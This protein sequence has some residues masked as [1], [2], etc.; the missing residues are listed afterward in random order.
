MITYVS[1]FELEFEA[2]ARIILSENKMKRQTTN[3]ILYANSILL[4]FPYFVYA[5]RASLYLGSINKISRCASVSFETKHLRK[6]LLLKRGNKNSPNALSPFHFISYSNKGGEKW[7][8]LDCVCVRIT[9]DGGGDDG[10]GDIDSDGKLAYS[11]ISM[12]L[13][14]WENMNNSFIEYVSNNRIC[15]KRLINDKNNNRE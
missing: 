7:E 9:W 2:A 15:A 3:G 8:L 13:T 12:K 5:H 6:W 1:F 11:L 14:G 4:I 10:N